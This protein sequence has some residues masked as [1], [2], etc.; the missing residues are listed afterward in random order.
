MSSPNQGLESVKFDFY[1]GINQMNDKIQDLFLTADTTEA[2][3]QGPSVSV[4]MEEL[5]AAGKYH[6]Q[7]QTTLAFDACAHPKS[8]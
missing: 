2:E 7:Q 4:E 5:V 6:K 1:S 8:S 3:N